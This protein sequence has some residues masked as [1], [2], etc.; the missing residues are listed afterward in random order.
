MFLL[1]EVFGN[2]RY[3][4][5]ETRGHTYANEV[6]MYVTQSTPLLT[7]GRT[8]AVIYTRYCRHPPSFPS[9]YRLKVPNF[10]LVRSKRST[11]QILKIEPNHEPHTSN[12]LPAI[13]EMTVQR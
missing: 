7:K 12:S 1:V 11:R 4:E 9:D 10:Q 5:Q 2:P 8:C 6:Y 13:H 3:Q